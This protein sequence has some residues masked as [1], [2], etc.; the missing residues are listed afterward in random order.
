[1][2]GVIGRQ[3]SAENGE[4]GRMILPIHEKGTREGGR[5]KGKMKLKEL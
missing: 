3:I 4:I 1:M 2:C 5:E